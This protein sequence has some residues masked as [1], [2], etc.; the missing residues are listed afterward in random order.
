MSDIEEVLTIRYKEIELIFE[1]I[2]KY[3]T[4]EIRELSKQLPVLKSTLFLMF[5]NAIES[6]VY[7]SIQ[8][9]FDDIK[10]NCSSFHLLT[11]KIQ[12]V[13]LKYYTSLRH[14][15]YNIMF[16]I[17]KNINNLHRLTYEEYLK[18]VSLFSGN[19]DA[20]KIRDILNRFGI[21]NNFHVKDEDKLLLIKNIRNKL[22]HG[23]NSFN[24]IG[25]NYTVNDMQ[26]FSGIV[27]NY[28][29]EL[30]RLIDI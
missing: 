22:A 13:Y 8:K 14:K 21:N 27:F 3:D 18:N 2:Q 19:L 15:N 20:Y 10:I 24:E 17:L 5:Y 26:R 25:R 23:E 12:K 6:T 28:L 30:C 1:L 11:E 29:S 16:S 4:G 9:I 7:V